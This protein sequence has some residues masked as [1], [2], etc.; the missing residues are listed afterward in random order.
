MPTLASLSRGRLLL[1]A[2]IVAAPLRSHAIDLPAALAL[3]AKSSPSLAAARQETESYDGAI[4]QAGVL[5]NPTLSFENQGGR[6]DERETTWLLTQPLEAPSKR[7]SRLAVAQ[8]EQQTAA[9]TH[10]LRG[11][12]L[13]GRVVAAFHELLLAQERVRL[14]DDG[15]H[16]AIQARS[17]VARR[18]AAG[19]LSP[20][21]ETRAGV[22]EAQARLERAQH[23]NA[24]LLAARRLAALCGQTEPA[25]ADGDMD[26]LPPVPSTADM[27]R[28]IAGA[29]AVQQAQREWRQRRA[30]AQLARADRLP[31]I[32]VTL[33][34]K[35]FG[36]TGHRATVAG[37]AIPLPLFDRGQGTVLQASR[38]AEQAETAVQAAELEV[39]MAAEQ[40]AAELASAREAATT[41][42]DDV[43]PAALNAYEAAGKG[44][45]Y[46]KFGLTDVL[47][48][49][50]TLLQAR[51][52]YLD[53][54]AAGHRAAGELE[55]LLGHR[56][57]HPQ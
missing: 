39:R 52:G 9:A 54:L 2:C 49:Q 25:R 35:R 48:A 27:A 13:H 3:A 23:D 31:D 6:R 51:A 32:A 46:G 5:P 36:E 8:A 47:D 50:R 12:E 57:G 38:R 40:A 16:L 24:R 29:P 53:T 4:R 55:R 1:C 34:T 37:I 22:A 21:D 17:T 41:L 28:L 14:A 30:Q 45:E 26:G 42:K 15:V 33:G 43:I 20:V 44:L 18:V 11:A 7:S 56:E 10:A 19:K